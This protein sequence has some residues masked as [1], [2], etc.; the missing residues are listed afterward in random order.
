[1]QDYKLSPNDPGARL[2]GLY[3]GGQVAAEIWYEPT[4]YS[5]ISVNGALVSIGPTGSLRV[6]LGTRLLERMFIGPETEE[7]WCGNFEEYQLGVHITAL[8]TDKLEWSA[9]TGWAFAS[10]PPRWP[11]FPDRRQY[12]VLSPAADHICVR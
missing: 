1:V 6:A 12:E 8:R 4:S 3:I 10:D 2:H 5:T 7:I 9:G 11:V